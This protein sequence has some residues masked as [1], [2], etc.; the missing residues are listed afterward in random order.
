MP[1]KKETV[2][3]R[4][5]RH[6]RAAEKHLGLPEGSV[7]TTPS[8]NLTQPRGPGLVYSP[9]KAGG[10]AERARARGRKGKGIPR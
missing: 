10:V 2:V 7:G 6:H 3:R 5:K 8:L 4:Q 9:A 1:A